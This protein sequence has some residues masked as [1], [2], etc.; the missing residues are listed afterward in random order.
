MNVLLISPRQ[1]KAIGGIATWTEHYLAK[2]NQYDLNCTLV[3]T[4]K[5]TEK[6]FAGWSEIGRTR[7]ISSDLK[8]ALSAQ[9]FDI[10]HLNTSCGLFG[11]FR[12][13]LIAQKLHKKGIPIVTHYHCDIPNW[14][15]TPIKRYVF[16]KLAKLSFLNFVLCENSRSYLA[17]FHIDSIKVPNCVDPSVVTD[18]PKEIRDMFTRIFFVGRVSKEKG[19]REIYELARRFPDKVFALAGGI[20]PPVDIWE[21]PDNVQLL[22]RLTSDNVIRLLDQADLFLFPSHTEGFSIA[23]VEAMARGVPCLA[24]D[25]V[26]ANSDMLADDCGVTVP[27]GDIDALE[28]AIRDLESPTKRRIISENAVAKVRNH[29]TTDAVL[30]LFKKLYSGNHSDQ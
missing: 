12:D 21:K 11:I 29:Y 16:K 26:G 25:S 1:S 13:Y 15:H 18:K 6:T 3:N 14:I 10:A 2:C 24:F 28:Q 9:H 17:Q 8:Q 5:G 4:E 22:G 23:L 30:S 27:L 20:V 19:A 7:R